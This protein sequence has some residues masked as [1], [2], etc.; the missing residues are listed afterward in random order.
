[1]DESSRK[2]GVTVLSS[3]KKID[4]HNFDS[5]RVDSFAYVCVYA[6]RVEVRGQYQASSSTCSTLS[7]ETGH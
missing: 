7:F 5:L 2:C 1:M 3:V 6:E 4:S